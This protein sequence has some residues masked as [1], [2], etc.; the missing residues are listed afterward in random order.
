MKNMTACLTMLL[1]HMD[2]PNLVKA[3]GWRPFNIIR[4]SSV[5]PL[6]VWSLAAWWSTIIVLVVQLIAA[7][8]LS[9]LLVSQ[10]WEIFLH[11]VPPLYWQWTRVHKITHFLIYTC[12]FPTLNVFSHHAGFG[13]EIKKSSWF[14]T[15]LC[16]FLVLLCTVCPFF[17]PW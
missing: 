16:T 1:C 14:S 13:L 4:P 6:Y 3:Q 15:C 12:A 17:T 7:Y 11:S 9:S 10:Q 2:N 5:W 8:L